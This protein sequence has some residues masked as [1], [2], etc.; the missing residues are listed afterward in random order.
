MPRTIVRFSRE[1]FRPYR[2]VCLMM[3]ALTGCGTM[4]PAA[5]RIAD[6]LRMPDTAVNEQLVS[7]WGAKNGNV[8]PDAPLAPGFLV[9]LRCLEDAKINGEYRVDFDGNLLLPYDLT[10]NAS[11]KTPAELE[12]KLSQLYRPYFRGAFDIGVKL[13]ERK[14]WIDVRGL[15][16][17]P[18]RYLID[19][20]SSMDTVIGAAGGLAKESIPMYA[21]IQKDSKVFILDLK[22]YYTLGEAQSQILGWIGGETVFLQKEFSRALGD[23]ATSSPYRRHVYMMGEIR[24]P[25]QYTLAPEADF[26]DSLVQAG[27]FTDRANID[28]IQVIRQSDGD[29]KILRFSWDNLRDAPSPREGDIVMV[30]ADRASKAEKRTALVGAVISAA[31]AAVTATIFV[32]SYKRGRL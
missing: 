22:R 5:P 8:G 14:Y 3:A 25:G 20:D 1:L 17:K 18:G 21:R 23:R 9:A 27:G 31:A 28:D 19:P 6:M 32:L 2:V 26:V 29:R 30:R 13:R 7:S 24:Q 15:V 12:Q 4:Q 11:G 10:V 16:E